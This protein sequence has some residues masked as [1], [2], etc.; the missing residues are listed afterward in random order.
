MSDHG[1]PTAASTLRARYIRL[2]L[3]CKSCRHQRHADLQGLADSGR[4][5]V[6]L[7]Q[8]TG[9]SV[10]MLRARLED[11]FGGMLLIPSPTGLA[12]RGRNFARKWDAG[13]RRMELRRARALFRQGWS[14]DRVRAELEAQY[15]Q[16]RD[17]RRTGIVRM[18][19]LGLP[20]PQIAAISGHKI[21]H[22]QEII[23]TYLPSRTE[24]ALAAMAAWEA[25]EDAATHSA[26]RVVRLPDHAVRKAP[27]RSRKS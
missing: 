16:R 10:P 23:D 24:V 2:L 20:T 17:L 13:L 25:A 3:T 26:A 4:G 8:N 11:P 27:P 12:W 1:L 21:D 22:R 18:A 15:R 9:R 6:P 7:I 5:D 19:E 14:K